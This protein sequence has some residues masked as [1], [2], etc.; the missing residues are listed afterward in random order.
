MMTEK[1]SRLL[2]RLDADIAA[3]A[4][5][6]LQA[7]LLRAERASHR[8]RTSRQPRSTPKPVTCKC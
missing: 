4:R 5:E 1:P 8:R 3:A 2:N 7:D 6:P